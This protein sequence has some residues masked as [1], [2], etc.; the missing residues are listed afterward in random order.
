MISTEIIDYIRQEIANINKELFDV[1]H[2]IWSNPETRFKEH[3]AHD[4]LTSY[5][6]KQEG[7]KVSKHTFGLETSFDCTFT[8]EPEKNPTVISF[9]SEYDALPGI[10]HSCGHNLIAIAGV[11]AALSVSKAMQKFNLPGTVKLFGTPGEEGGG[12]KIKMVE[13]GAYDKVDVSLM[14]HPMNH[15]NGAYFKSYAN[16]I[17]KVEFFGK[18]AHAAVAPWEGVNALDALVITYNAISVLRQ[19]FRPGDIMQCV[20]SDA[21]ESAN[22][23]TGYSAG[24]FRVRGPTIQRVKELR[25]CLINC[26]KAG[27]IATGCEYKI[28]EQTAYADMISNEII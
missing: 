1:Q 24:E 25:K 17:N 9:N 2:S 11:V 23:I 19:Q 14:C 12:G 28:E 15:I 10:G 6:E 4:T 3:F 16:S 21:G 18:T 26:V 20:F 5:M 8:N 13:A 7:W 27:S 22:I